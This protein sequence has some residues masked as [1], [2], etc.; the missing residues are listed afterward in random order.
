MNVKSD[1]LKAALK[2][3]DMVPMRAGIRPSEFVRMEVESKRLSFS[4][5][6]DLIGAVSVPFDGSPDG[7]P[8]EFFFDRGQFLPLVQSLADGRDVELSTNGDSVVLR[9]GSKRATYKAL[10]K[11][12]GYG[13]IQEPAEQGIVLDS[14][15]LAEVSSAMNYIGKA[16]MS[17]E[18]M[19]VWYDPGLPGFLSTDRF[20]VY[21]SK[22]RLK[23]KQPIVLPAALAAVCWPGVVLHPGDAWVTVTSPEGWFQQSLMKEMAQQFPAKAVRRAVDGASKYPVHARFRAG[24]VADALGRMR[25]CL[26]ST[27]VDTAS[28]RADFSPGKLVLQLEASQVEIKE[29]VKV[30]AEAESSQT[31]DWLLVS[32]L[33]F[34]TDLPSDAVVE[35]A[36][37]DASPFAFRCRQPDRILLSP[38]RA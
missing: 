36:W 10:E 25:S 21:A 7:M 20:S 14:V 12:A 28:V 3:L 22:H 13:K 1:R 9:Q 19:A 2:I 32:L 27:A 6:S 38:R 11:V 29:T 8:K 24:R 15:V 34:L 30:E 31:C 5:A 4:L 18:L 26:P 33:P 16:S 17:P 37:E 23:S 35:A